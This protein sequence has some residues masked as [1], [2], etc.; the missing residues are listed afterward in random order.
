MKLQKRQNDRITNV[1]SLLNPSII[2]TRLLFLSHPKK[3]GVKI[4]PARHGYYGTQVYRRVSAIM[5]LKE[6]NHE[7]LN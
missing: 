5:G 2:Y 3:L 6:L 7:Q 1:N 4:T